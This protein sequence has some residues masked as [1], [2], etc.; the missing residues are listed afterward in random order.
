MDVKTLNV[1]EHLDSTLLI[2]SSAHY[3]ESI[4]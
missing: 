2:D 4:G 3:I 1:A